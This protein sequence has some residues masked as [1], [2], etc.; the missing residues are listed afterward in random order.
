VVEGPLSFHSAGTPAL[1]RRIAC[2]GLL[3]VVLFA[4]PA[5]A[6]FQTG[7]FNLEQLT[8]DSGTGPDPGTA[9]LQARLKWAVET[10]IPREWR[11]SVRV[12]WTVGNTGR[13]HLALSYLDGRT[14]VSPRLMTRS[15]EEVVA[16]VAHEMGHQIAFALVSPVIG[17]PPQ[18]FMDIAPSYSDI[19]EGWADCVARVWTG[20]T[21]RTLSESGPCSPETAAYVSSL[22]HDPATLGATVRIPPPPIHVPAPPAAAPVPVE[23]PPVLAPPPPIPDLVLPAPA[24]LRTASAQPAAASPKGTNGLPIALALIPLPLAICGA[25][26]LLVRK[27]SEGLLA[28]ATGAPRVK[29]P[30]SP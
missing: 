20:S 12:V 13:G 5:S 11:E 4:Q 26:Y 28:W 25:G 15:A 27:R 14:I 7:G 6:R 8:A 2:L 24:K 19:R 17:M 21:L 30:G 9:N 23:P 29:P 3:I 10:G 16:T 22:L 18:G 1:L